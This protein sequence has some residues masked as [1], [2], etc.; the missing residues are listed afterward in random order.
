MELEN[1]ILKQRP[2]LCQR[3]ENQITS[4]IGFSSNF[5][6]QGKCSVTFFGTFQ[7]SLRDSWS[8]LID[9]K[10]MYISGD[11]VTRTPEGLHLWMGK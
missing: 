7:R 3:E 2:E 4:E 8:F 1:Y 6:F 9:K 11:K 10:M 5:L